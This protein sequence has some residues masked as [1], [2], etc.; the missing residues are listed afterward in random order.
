MLNTMKASP[1][2]WVRTVLACCLMPF[3]VFGQFVWKKGDNTINQLGIYGTQGDYDIANK[4]GSRWGATPWVDASQ[5]MWLFGGEGYGASGSSGR[6]SDLWKYNPSSNQW[7]WVKGPSARNIGGTYGT[8]GVSAAAN[9]PGAREVAMNWIDAS[10]NLWIFGGYGYDANG[11]IG[12]LN[13]L[14]MYNQGTNEWTWMSGDTVKNKNGVYGTLG[15]PDAANKPGGRYHS[16]GTLDASGNLLLFS[17]SGYAESG[18]LPQNLNDLWRFNPSTGEW[19]WISG[20]KTGNQSGVYGTKGVPDASNKPGG[21]VHAVSWVDA[22]GNMWVFSGYGKASAAGNGYLNDLFK[23]DIS[24]G[25]WT[26]ISGDNVVNQ[27]GVYSDSCFASTTN[28]P[29]SR[30]AAVAWGDPSTD[31]F[32]LYGGQGFDAGTTVGQLNDLWVFDRVSET[33]SWVRGG[34]INTN[35]TYGTQEVPDWANLPGG[36]NHAAG[37]QVAG[38]LWLFGGA[39]YPA[40]GGSGILND[41][42]RLPFN[43]PCNGFPLPISLV[44]FTAV[45]NDGNGTVGLQ[46]ITASEENT[47]SF[48]VERSADGIHFA[49]LITLPAAGNSTSLRTYEATDAGPLDGTAF[50]RLAST[51]YDGTYSVE[52][53]VIFIRRN[54]ADHPSH[55]L[56]VFPNPAPSGGE[57]YFSL[58]SPVFDP[59][60]IMLVNKT[61]RRL[62][63]ATYAPSI[64]GIDAGSLDLP[65]GLPAGAYHVLCITREAVFGTNLIIR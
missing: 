47:A 64:T 48:T 13:D 19:T 6:L 18:W 60:D 46:W 53:K 24:S 41:Q 11:S 4:P 17:G 63:A 33:W 58:R 43:T 62:Q 9:N 15:V 42:W 45:N 16:V 50:Y 51:S 23:Y 26:W 31:L 32:W 56:T 61:G 59:F 2:T 35:G 36:R 37:W 14:W 20:D 65:P 3:S 7:M 10:G 55:G 52:S 1:G 57:I 5:Y 22:G 40:T 21:R 38:A 39:G 28:K 44:S 27:S 8:R 49:R 12:Y 29:G 30:Q 34:T 25:L 54:T